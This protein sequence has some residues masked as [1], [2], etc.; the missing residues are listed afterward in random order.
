MDILCTVMKD[1]NRIESAEEFRYTLVREHDGK[2]K[3]SKD[4]LW[5]EWNDDRTFKETHREPAVGRSLIMSPFNKY[6]TWQ[7]T[8]ICEIIERTDGLI[9]FRTKNS[10]YILHLP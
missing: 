1:Q 8:K 9:S 7:T 3:R 5:I 10:N 4:V 6:F 2:T